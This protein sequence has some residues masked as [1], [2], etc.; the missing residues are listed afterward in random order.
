MASL[1]NTIMEVVKAR[2]ETVRVV[3]G[4]S[5][6]IADVARPRREGR[7]APQHLLAVITHKD[8]EHDEDLSHPGNPPAVAWILPVRI[9]GIV[10]PSDLIETAIDEVA[11]SFGADLQ[12]AIA[13]PAASWQTFSDN[14]INATIGPLIDADDVESDDASGKEFELRIT[15]RVDETDPNNVRG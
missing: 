11:D 8:I 7:Y 5:H 6:D 10:F 4:Y 9:V 14:A 3:N 1:V 13:V 2:L 12:K 15:Y